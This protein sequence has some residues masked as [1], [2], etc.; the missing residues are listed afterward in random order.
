MGREDGVGDFAGALD[1]GRGAVV[2]EVG[3]FRVCHGAGN[4]GQ[5]G[6]GLARLLDNLAGFEAIWD[7]EN[8]R[9]RG[10]DID[11]A[12]A[13]DGVGG[14]SI[15]AAFA[16]FGDGVIAVV[17]DDEG[18]AALDQ[19]VADDFANAAVADEHGVIFL[20]RHIVGHVVVGGALVGGNVAAGFGGRA[21]AVEEMEDQRVQ[22]DGDD[23][24]G[25]D[26]FAAFLGQDI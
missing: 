15:D 7:R 12:E 26:Q 11:G 4:D 1:D 3:F 14:N 6:V 9:A 23:G 13:R 17:D 18:F 25:Q 8:E 21:V 24:T 16:E 5:R 19:F 20:P 22:Y 10:L 2:L